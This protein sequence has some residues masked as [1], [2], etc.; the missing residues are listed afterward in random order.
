MDVIVLAGEKKDSKN[1]SGEEKINKAFYKIKDKHMIEYVV[2]TLRKSSCIDKIA[3]VGPKDKLEE[4]I[5][6]IVDFV[7]E[8]ADSIVSNILLTLD[9]FPGEKEILIVTSDIPMITKEAIEDFV[10]RA[11]QKDADLCYS[12]VDKKVND[13]KYPDVR[14]TYARLWEGQFTGGNVFYFNPDVTDKCKDFVG[15]MLEYRK[16]PTKMARVLGFGFL[17]RLALGILTINAVQ[18]KCESLLGI[19]GAAI[20]SPYPEI[21]NDVDRFSDLEFIEKYM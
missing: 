4:V 19:R 5:G 18:K 16:S 8:G 12:I 6:G 21:G 17:L 1:G 3:V 20:I 11:R 13:L 10:A 15:K 9:C 2:E 7:V 14:R